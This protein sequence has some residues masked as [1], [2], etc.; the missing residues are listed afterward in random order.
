MNLDK[1]LSIENLS[2][3]YDKL[4]ILHDI[5]IPIQKGEIVA[6]IGRNGAGKSTLFNNIMGIN[7]KWSGKVL[8]NDIDISDKDS[9]YIFKNGISY[10]PQGGKIFPQLTIFEN[11]I[12]NSGYRVFT[13]KN[14]EVEIEKLLSTNAPKMWE[15][16]HKRLLPNLDSN[17]GK[18]SGG[19]RQ[20]LSIIRTFM[21]K[22]PL[23]LLDEPTIG[24][25][26]PLIAELENLLKAESISNSGILFIEQKV[27][28]SLKIC[29]K[30]YIM[31]RGKIAYEGSPKPI[32][33]DEAL[34][35]KLMG[36]SIATE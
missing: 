25:S 8:L 29:D 20:L 10:L 9:S 16:T 31:Q 32:L 12:F 22:K 23:F 18:L 5:S 11:L 28:W 15:H 3:G 21:N 30:V 19:E 2:S 14:I 17:A 35:S 26:L 33:T 1:L 13:K 4:Q 6:L 34:L 36:L 24:L 27:R 7:K